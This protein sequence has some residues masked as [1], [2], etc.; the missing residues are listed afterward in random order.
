MVRRFFFSAL[1]TALVLFRGTAES[2]TE[3]EAR[4]RFLAVDLTEEAVVV[5]AIVVLL[6]RY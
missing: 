6:S 3:L 1:E 5:E 2:A 4:E